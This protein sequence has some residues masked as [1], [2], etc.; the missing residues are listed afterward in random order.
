LLPPQLFTMALGQQAAKERGTR[1]SP[2]FHLSIVKRAPLGVL[3]MRECRS[4]TTIVV[5]VTQLM[6]PQTSPGFPPAI[7][8]VSLDLQLLPSFRIRLA[9]PARK[10]MRGCWAR[11]CYQK[12]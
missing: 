1:Q 3:V 10:G 2:L 12:S 7:T 11:H 9:P 6:G 4:A 8:E 5:N